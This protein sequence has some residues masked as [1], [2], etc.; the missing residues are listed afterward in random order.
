VFIPSGQELPELKA[1][2]S[3]VVV[4]HNGA[5]KIAHFHNTPVDAEAERNDPVTWDETG[6][7]PG[8]SEVREKL[9]QLGLSLRGD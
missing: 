5:W 1:R 9:R 3:F 2:A 8:R 6:Y 4:K 7:L